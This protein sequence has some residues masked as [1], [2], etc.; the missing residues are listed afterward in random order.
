MEKSTD[1]NIE[2]V[3]LLQSRMRYDVM[4][5][6]NVIDLILVALLADGHVLLED[7]PGSGKTTLAKALGESISADGVEENMSAFRRMQFTPDLLPGDITG[8]M[9]F[10]PEANQFY[11]RRGPIFT[12]IALVD[13]INRT[14]PK[15]QSALLESMGEKQVTIDN[16]THKLSDLFFVIATQNPLDAVGTYPLPIAQLDRFMFKIRMTNI[17][18]SA[19]LEV[20]RSWGR[21]REK[22]QMPQVTVQ[23]ILE[24][25]QIVRNKVAVADSVM[26]CLVD[27]IRTIREDP[28]C[29]QGASTRSLVQ[30]VPALQAYAFMKGRM[31]VA[32]SDIEDLGEPLFS[33]RLQLAPGVGD[34][35]VVVRDAMN[36][37][38]HRLSST[39]LHS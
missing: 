2:I 15:V 18:R 5:R 33:H 30:A 3:K 27:I 4:G 38:L 19:E 34:A 29:L 37:P 36:A 31:Y 6:D 20:I 35:G 16:V 28:R 8:V 22:C 1:P 24:V 12:H 10:D 32:A 17:S 39:L 9:V 26:E 25:R 14:S 11:F 23:Q 21:P 7:F 13:E